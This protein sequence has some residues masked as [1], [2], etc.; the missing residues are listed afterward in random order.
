MRVQVYRC[1][2]CNAVFDYDPRHHPKARVGTWRRFTQYYGRL[3][4]RVVAGC[5]SC[6]WVGSLRRSTMLD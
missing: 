4:F 6:G 1:P 2:T 5:P 3:V